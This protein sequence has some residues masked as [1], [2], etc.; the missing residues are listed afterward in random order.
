MTADHAIGPQSRARMPDRNAG[1]FG[2]ASGEELA[3]PLIE[4]GF[5]I[6]LGVV[7]VRKIAIDIIPKLLCP[8]IALAR[9]PGFLFYD[10][11]VFGQG[12]FEPVAGIGGS[13][14]SQSFRSFLETIVRRPA[15]LAT[16]RPAAISVYRKLLPTPTSAIHSRI[17]S[18]IL[19]AFSA[20]GP[21]RKSPWRAFTNS[22]GRWAW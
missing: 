10:V 14:H 22:D 16:K 5:T 9:D 3:G 12:G 13:L 4:I 6:D 1:G 18:A 2:K 17:E 19:R 15:F 11:D 7:L 8:G 21:L 20:I